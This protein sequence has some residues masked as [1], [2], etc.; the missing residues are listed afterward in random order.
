[1]PA[2]LWFA[3]TV[4]LGAPE[5]GIWLPTSG[6]AGE[7]SVQ[8]I[9]AGGDSALYAAGGGMLYRLEPGAEWTRIGRYAPRL[10]WERT[11]EIVAHGNLPPALLRQVE[12]DAERLVEVPDAGGG[13]ES[14]P[15]ETM[16]ALLAEFVEE[17]SRVSRSPYA[18][19]QIVSAPHGAWIATGGG[20]FR[21]TRDGVTGPR[22]DIRG[23]INTVLNRKD[24]TL[25]GTD[26]GLYRIPPDA[27]AVEV[28]TGSVTALTESEGSL[29]FIADGRLFGGSSVEAAHPLEGPAPSP[30]AMAADESG[31]YL[32]TR[33]AVYRRHTGAWSLCAPVPTTPTRLV[34]SEGILH[35]L[36]EDAVYLFSESCGQ[37]T[38]ATPPWPGGFTFTDVARLGGLV[39]ASSNEGVFILSPLDADT[40]M[41]VQMEGYR[42]AV[43]SI[44]S[45]DV[46]VLRALEVHRLDADAM[47]YESRRPWANLLPEVRAELTYAPR[48]VED[49]DKTTRMTAIEVTKAKPSWT[50]MAYWTVDLPCFIGFCSVS[51]IEYVE[52]AALTDDDLSEDLGDATGVEEISDDVTADIVYDDE[53][54]SLADGSGD[55]QDVLEQA[56][57]SIMAGEKKRNAVDRG[58]V[59]TQLRRLYQQRQNL[60]YRL[61]VQ[62]SKDLQQ[63]TTLLLSVDELDARLSA[64]TGLTIRSTG[65]RPAEETQR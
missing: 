39:W 36:A 42:R 12:A 15:R 16:R 10:T 32:A 14:V 4:L 56:G 22:A 29:F 2:A 37:V 50:I 58:K 3:L 57:L 33:F 60:L 24:E 17:Q 47:S 7:R 28:R 54:L 19:A 26:A 44:P 27:P 45:L 8:S 51:P 43:A 63:R 20:L 65:E 53:A 21:A 49:Y 13:I 31:L 23:A 48:R 64:M 40:S 59:I 46:L 6:R 34:T 52:A 18:V 11:G 62:R 25:V 9:G 1:M 5:G 55:A 30:L 38:Q 41:T 61:W 35:A